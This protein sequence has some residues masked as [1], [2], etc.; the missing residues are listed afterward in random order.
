MGV[1]PDFRDLFRELNAAEARYLVVGAHAVTFYS[2][3]RYTKDLD[4]WV[5]VDARNAKRVYSAL[6]SFGAPLHQL[7]EEDLSTPETVFQIGV[8]PNRIDILTTVGGVEF[9]DAWRR[10]AESTYGEV[11][12]W[13]VDRDDLIV[14]KRAA[15][16][17]QDLL[18]LVSL[19]SAR[20]R[21]H[22]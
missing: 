11:Q 12:I 17:P 15:G 5:G 7:T 22:E 19:E 1:N 21:D 6:A 20:R 2:T 4:V 3:P 8:E 14:C 13:I 16:R 9:D 10:R 18:D